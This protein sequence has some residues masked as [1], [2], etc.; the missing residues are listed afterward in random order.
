[1][2][3]ISIDK[4]KRKLGF[5]I[6]LVLLIIII[7]SAIRYK[8][9]FDNNDRYY[10]KKNRRVLSTTVIPSWKITKPTAVYSIITAP[11][12]CPVGSRMNHRCI[13]VTQ[14]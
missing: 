6:L 11:D 9:R 13:R 5:V 10:Y 7:E 14:F 1:M 4:I 12:I 8:N 3:P 2:I